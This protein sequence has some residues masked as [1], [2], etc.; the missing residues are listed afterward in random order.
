MIA[1][2]QVIT[3]LSGAT[4]AWPLAARAQQAAMPVIGFLAI[5]SRDTYGYLTDAFR[6]GLQEAGYVDGKNVVIEYRWADN[7]PDRLPVLAADLVR[8]QVAVIAAVGGL[9]SPRAA[10]AATTTIPIV[11]TT[12]G[13]PV[14]LA[15]VDS[16]SRPGGNATGM[17]VFSG[18]L[19]AKR[20]QVARELMPPDSLLATLMNQ[21]NP[22]NDFD[23]KD[24][25]EAAR[26]I[27]QRLVTVNASSESELVVA[28]ETVTRQQAKALLVGNDV[29]FNSRRDQVVALAARYAVPT[30]YFQREAVRAGGLISYGASIP[31]VYR[32]V[33]IYVSRILK[34]EKPSNLPVLQPTR[35]ELVINLVTAKALGLDIPPTVVALAD[36]VIE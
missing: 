17:S 30:M 22:E 7:H 16:L 10:K 15:L 5:S 18:T 28:F 29:F 4:A 32:N 6:Q 36:E 31:D 19:L 20:L 25:Q 9:A 26:A 12:G 14:S 34:G 3:L 21:T 35:V 13:D 2:R 24:L 8:R 11:F 1:R 33:G 27:G 23:T